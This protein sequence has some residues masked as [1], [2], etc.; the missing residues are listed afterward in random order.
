MEQIQDYH[1]VTDRA[2]ERLRRAI[3]LGELQPGERLKAQH[4]AKEYGISTTPINQAL[5]RL[6]LEG[7]VMRTPL[8][9]SR[10]SEGIESI[11]AEAGLLR[12]ALEGVAAY[13]AA[14]KAGE[15]DLL[16]LN[17]Q[18]EAMEAATEANDLPL[19]AAANTKFHELIHTISSNYA[20][21]Q[22]LGVVRSIDG[23]MR[24]KTLQRINEMRLG[25]SEH[26]GI[27]EAISRGDAKGSRQL[28][29]QHVL[30]SAQLEKHNEDQQTDE[31]KV[32]HSGS[33]EAD[34]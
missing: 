6:E 32:A 33:P 2:S 24:D 17:A 26:H 14:Q 20:L 25:L 9:G 18:F 31:A 1:S 19:T 23:A 28:M 7:L 8:R 10:V 12:S 5:Q 34:L 30:R 21:K 22:M 16:S 3:M 15:D 27:L 11:I 4:L 13:L 29:E